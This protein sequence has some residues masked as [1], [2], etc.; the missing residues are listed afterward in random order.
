MTICHSIELIGYQIQATSVVDYLMT[1]VRAK[2]TAILKEPKTQMM[3][4]NVQETKK[5]FGKPA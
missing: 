2:N 1:N 4:K 3:I 5:S